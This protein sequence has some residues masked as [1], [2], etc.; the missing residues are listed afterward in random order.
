M[1]L[2]IRQVFRLPGVDYSHVQRLH[3]RFFDCLLEVQIRLELPLLHVSSWYFGTYW[4][5][6]ITA[7]S[8]RNFS[9][10]DVM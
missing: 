8:V 1:C 5:F 10:R 4:E 9:F 2:Q 6:A 7:F 3:E